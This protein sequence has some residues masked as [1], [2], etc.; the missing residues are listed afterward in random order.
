MPKAL[1]I[2]LIVIASLFL[3][4]LLFITVL[5]GITIS[6]TSKLTNSDFIEIGN[7]QIKSIRSVV[8]TRKV[9]SYSFKKGKELES[10]CLEYKNVEKPKNDLITYLSYLRFEENYLVT[11]SYNLNNS[12]G[13]L[14]IAKK[15]DNTNQLILIDI[16]WDM[17]SYL[18]TYS[19]GTGSL[20][21]Y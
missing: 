15:V 9:S 21:L 17:N 20:T 4:F 2:T 8:D 10:K 12:S 3:V 11:K 13:T 19:Y 14:Q 18:I 1:K 6:T 5:F 16:T 7:T